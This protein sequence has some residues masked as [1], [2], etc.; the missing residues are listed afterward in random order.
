MDAFA[1]AV[2][3]S[4][5]TVVG[6]VA[7]VMAVIPRRRARKTISSA[8]A[9]GVRLLAE[10]K[11]RLSRGQSL[12]VGESLYSPG[13]R[14]RFTLQDDA[15]MV[16]FVD[17]LGDICDTG[18]SNVGKPE[19]LKLDESGW[20]VLY[21]VDGHELW[22]KGQRGDHLDVQDN[23][24]VALYPATGDAIWATDLFFKAGMLVRW[25]PPEAR[26]RW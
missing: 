11:S 22:K 21:D 23:S 9:P 20:L 10:P 2:I 1:V 16:V 25:I 15:N 19:R 14:T 3:G 7:A 5:A 12:L 17:G 24:H 26:V 8:D 13:G 6:A 4:V 18:T